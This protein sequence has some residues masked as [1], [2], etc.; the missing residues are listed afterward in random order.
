MNDI[1]IPGF[2]LIERLGA[3]GMATVW[4]ARQ[5]SLDRIVAIKMLSSGLAADPD[6]VRMF[7]VE[8]QTTAKLKHPGIVQVYDANVVNGIYYFVMEYV[9][10]Y[11]VGEWLRRNGVLEEAEAL[12]VAECVS[13]ALQYAWHAG[14]IIHCDIKPDNVM[15]DAD[16]TVKVTD[17]G[18]ARM[19]DAV[20]GAAETEITGTPAYMSPEQARGDPALDLRTDIYAT[21]AMLYQLLTGRLMFEGEPCERVIDLQING[22]VADPIDINAAVTHPA[23][24]LVEGM[25]AKRKEDRPDSWEAVQQDI[26]RVKQGLLPRHVLPP[27]AV[28]TIRRSRRRR[29]REYR[30]AAH[31]DEGGPARQRVPAFR[32]LAPGVAVLAAAGLALWWFL[33]A[34]GV[35]ESPEAPPAAAPPAAAVPEPDTAREMYAFAE[36]WA[37]A[38]PE[39]LDGA[40]ARFR[41]VADQTRGTK[42][43]LM[44]ADAAARLEREQADRQRNVMQELEARTAQLIAENRFLE[45]AEVYEG[46]AGR[47]SGATEAARHERAQALRA[48]QA[49]AD[50]ERAR[51]ERLAGERFEALVHE[52]AALLLDSGLDAARRRHAEAEADPVLA[53]RAADLAAVGTVLNGAANIGRRVIESFRK[54]VGETLVVETVN[55]EKTY[56]IAGV[57]DAGVQVEY[58]LGSGRAVAELSL[59]VEDLSLRERLRR[60]GADDD[61]DVALVKGLMAWSA[62]RREVAEHYCGGT[63]PLLAGALVEG[64]RERAAAAASEAPPREAPASAPT[65]IEGAEPVTPDPPPAPPAGPRG[66][67]AGPPPRPPQE[68]FGEGPRRL[69]EPAERR[70]WE[71]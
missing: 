22:Q 15:V 70:W 4:K 12:L 37:E 21:G 57:G 62:G 27:S 56:Y 38:H 10:G 52:V 39:A 14:D 44:A 13:D 2:E 68:G 29:L 25:T 28:S 16:G 41:E 66:P 65:G 19:I 48:R 64:V 45:A 49:D 63:H 42:F 11:T 35:A 69:N 43:A 6:D 18:L 36:A 23:A 32:Y 67:G 33:R 54:Q 30:Q 26:Q 46:Y 31:G 50:Q 34:G 60:M 17:L 40:A 47:L 20:S 1:A 61:P 7:Q 71:E 8:A 59:G 5:V 51:R 58:R 55:G 53:P 9:A 24:W 3:G